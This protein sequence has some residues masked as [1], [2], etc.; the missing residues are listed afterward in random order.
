METIKHGAQYTNIP[1]FTN[2]TQTRH[3]NKA[4][5]F[6]VLTPFTNCSNQEGERDLERERE[7]AMASMALPSI[8]Y[9]HYSNRRASYRTPSLLH[10]VVSQS[11]QQDQNDKSTQKLGRR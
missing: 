11:Q 5:G 7:R 9:R 1:F 10:I 8:Y 4:N 6:S 2:Q 3:K